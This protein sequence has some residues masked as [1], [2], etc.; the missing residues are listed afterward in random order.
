[1]DINYEVDFAIMESE[2]GS[3]FV[4]TAIVTSGDIQE[5]FH[6]FCSSEGEV[7][8]SIKYMIDW[9]AEGGILEVLDNHTRAN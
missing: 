4:V 9:L 8:E 3:M 5:I 6:R 1:M 7:A 2:T